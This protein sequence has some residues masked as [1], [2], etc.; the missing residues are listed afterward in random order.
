MSQTDTRP[1][2]RSLT[3]DQTRTRY[4]GLINGGHGDLDLDAPYQR[5][6]VWCEERQRNLIR[7]LTM[8]L[9]TAAIFINRRDHERP[10]VVIDGKQRITAVTR[11]LDGDLRV[12]AAWFP[13]D[14]A[15]PP[16][17]E[18][19]CGEWVAFG[20][21]ARAGRLLWRT[22]ATVAVYWTRFTGPDAED[23]E[24]ELFDLINYGGVPQGES[25]RDARH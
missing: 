12:P 5:G 1:I 19:G 21:L 25:D 18:P 11:W 10:A 4:D 22:N 24:R 15:D 20:D 9:S 14:D 2:F 23:R 8:G 17:V 16:I 3:L 7:S 13:G 6:H